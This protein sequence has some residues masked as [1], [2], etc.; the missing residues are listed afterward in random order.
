MSDMWMKRQTDENIFQ[1]EIWITKSLVNAGFVRPQKIDNG[2]L[3]SHGK[4]TVS[5]TMVEIAPW[6]SNISVIVEIR[7]LVDCSTARNTVS[8]EKQNTISVHLFPILWLQL[9]TS[10]CLVFQWRTFKYFKASIFHFFLDEW[11]VKEKVGNTSVHNKLETPVTV[12]S[13]CKEVERFN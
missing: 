4:T 13:V 7:D 3:V 8:L 11:I 10:K 5:T 1:D 9:C 2:C 12:Q 6:C